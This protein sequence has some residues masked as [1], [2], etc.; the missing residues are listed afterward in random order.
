MDSSKGSSVVVG[1]EGSEDGTV[2]VFVV[3]DDGGEGEESLQDAGGDAGEAARGVA[4]E[5]ELKLEGLVDRL[6]DLRE[7]P[8]EALSGTGGVVAE[9]G[10]GSR[11]RRERPRRRR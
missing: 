8:Q 10:S 11:W 7:R 9:G 4:F 5:V 6:D 2:G 3:P 1:G